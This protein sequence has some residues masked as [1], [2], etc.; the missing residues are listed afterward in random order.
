MHRC[1]KWTTFLPH[2]SS[3]LA[4]PPTGGSPL[5]CEA[6]GS[7]GGGIDVDKM[8]LGKHPHW[9]DLPWSSLHVSPLACLSSLLFPS[10]GFLHRY[11]AKL[12]AGD[13]IFIPAAWCVQNASPAGL[14]RA[15]S[16]W[17]WILSRECTSACI[18]MFLLQLASAA[19]LS[20]C[21]NLPPEPNAKQSGARGLD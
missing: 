15:L 16:V 11:D 9:A 4:T 17:T 6:Y 1:E 20:T 18:I 19:S 12:D 5:S 3:I 8:D 21:G 14:Y 13:C 2:T 7:Y 10:S